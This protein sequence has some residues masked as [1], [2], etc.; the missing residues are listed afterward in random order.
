VSDE[1]LAELMTELADE[2][3]RTTRDDAA[4]RAWA[5]A[6]RVRRRRVAVAGAIV[7]LAV[8]VPVALTQ[9]DADPGPPQVQAEPT[10]IVDRTVTPAN[11]RLDSL[12]ETLVPRTPS[13]WPTVLEP[14]VDAPSLAQAPIADPVLL[15][16]PFSQGPSYLYGSTRRSSDPGMRNSHWARLDVALQDTRDADGNSA[17]PVDANSLGPGGYVAFAQPGGL[18]TVSTATGEVTRTPLAGLHE[19][20]SWRPDGRSLFL[21]S[22]SVTVLVGL[23]TVSV[24]VAVTGWDVVLGGEAGS[25]VV[26]L[27]GGPAEDA[28]LTVRRYDATGMAK[29]DEFTLPAI[30]DHTVNTLM[31]R[32]WRSGDRIAQAAF[33]QSGQGPGNFVIVVNELSRSVTHLLELGFTGPNLGC[34][35]VLGWHDADTV[36]VYTS[37]EGLLAWHLPTGAVTLVLPVA[38]GTLSIA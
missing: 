8:A 3:Q 10:I 25:G 26:T 5:A 38:Q 29:L 30:A 32:A 6:G 22:A 23:T 7:A 20:V 17:S 2:L 15:F 18:V 27:S 4:A 36:L 34:C 19:E 1:R 33:G 31:G 9:L 16:Q 28:T 24:P 35:Q 13:G 21:S 11:L 37:Q 12:S 14:P